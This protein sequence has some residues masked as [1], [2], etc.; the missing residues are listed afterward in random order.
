MAQDDANCLKGTSYNG[1][2]Q[3]IQHKII[4]YFDERYPNLLLKDV[5]PKQIQDYYTYEMNENG[6]SANTAIHRH[7]NIRK[8]LQYAYQVDLIPTN[9]ADKVQ[10]PRKESFK[11]FPYKKEELDALLQAVKGTKLELGVIFAS[12]Y[13]LRRSEVYGLKWNAI[14]FKKKTISI[15][16]TVTQI[17]NGEETI[18]IQEDSTKTASSYRTLPLVEPVEK[19]LL[20]LREKQKV[21]RRICG[22]SYCNDYLEYIYVNEMGELVKPNYLTEA[23]PKFLVKH[24]MRKIRFHDLR[25]SCATMLYGNGVALKDIQEWLGHSDIST[26]SNIYTHLDFTSK[27]ASAN[28]TIDLLSD[29]EEQA[30]DPDEVTNKSKKSEMTKDPMSNK[31]QKTKK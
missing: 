22:S 14:D 4:P 30:K 28:A 13:G 1:Y 5:T 8:A 18:L 12:F 6:V 19:L 27:I 29:G 16:H 7:A 9:P 2:R 11:I 23:F 17:S 3:V 26:T 10:R 21:N 20:N 15:E 25:H 24:G 31:R